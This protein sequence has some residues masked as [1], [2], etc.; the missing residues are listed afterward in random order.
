MHAMLSASR[1]YQV[2]CVT[3]VFRNSFGAESYTRAQCKSRSGV[4]PSKARAPSNTDE[5]SQAA[6]VRGPKMPI[7]PS[8]QSPSKNVQVFDQPFWCAISMLLDAIAALVYGFLRLR[9][10]EIR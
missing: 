3:A 2:S 5:P 4:T 8:C 7:L 6:W 9:A 10:H 1:P